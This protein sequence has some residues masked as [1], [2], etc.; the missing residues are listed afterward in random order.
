MLNEKAEILEYG[1]EGDLGPRIGTLCDLFIRL[2]DHHR[3]ADAFKVKKNGQWID[4]STDEF[5]LRVQ[6]LFFALRALGIRPEDRVA[7]MSENRLEWATADYATLCAGAITVPIYPTL[8][9]AQVECLLLD[10]KPSVAF[11]SASALEKFTAAA[12]QSTCTRYVVAFDSPLD[13]PEI[14]RLESLFDVGRQAAF[15]YPGVFRHAANSVSPEAVATII[16]TSGT[17]G[18]PKG[19]MLTHR[20]LASNVMATSAVLPLR[21]DDLELSFLPLSHVFQRHVDYAAAFAGST[22]AYAENLNT[23]PSDLMELRPTFAA[24]VPRFFEKIYCRIMS[25]VEKA[26]AV[27]RAIFEKAMAVGYERLKTGRHSL[28]YRAA[29]RLVFRKIR[30]KLGG[31]IRWFIS[32]GAA[33]EKEIAQFFFAIGIPIM[34]GYGLTE[35]SPVIALTSPTSP[36]IGSV[37]K[38]VGDVEIQ[39]AGDGEI[40]VRGSNVMKGYFGMPA[41]TAE[42]LAGGWFHTGDI[43]EID[44]DRNLWITDRKKD[45]IVTS[46][47]K[48]IAPQPIENRL[49]L[50]PYF[51]NVVL[52]GDRRNFV[53]ALI[54]PNRAALE[55]YARS[56]NIP[57]ESVS[58]LV[59]KPEIVDLAMREIDK[60][61]TD[62]AGFEKIRRIAFLDGEF[63]IDGGE[64]TPTMKVRRSTI[65][66]KYKTIIDQ[67]YAA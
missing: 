13:A 63:T 51:D 18:V 5:V 17:T 57:F 4:I 64:L 43:G 14:L 53:A 56:H 34:E 2:A 40:L 45:L 36:R 50:I 21:Q 25:E 6:E 33:L 15:D 10:S 54:A 24:G 11:V 12:R 58:D 26:P 65:A 46:S 30:E 44:S 35:T 22:I 23:V 1:P 29:D 47:G 37:G 31:R 39:I 28:S 16:Y 7:I 62:L 49:K 20:N 32:G 52:I 19:A 48:N 67:L 61:T 3:K 60:R 66:Q 41:E 55:A 27:R 38:A 59:R 9:A 42:A 8:S